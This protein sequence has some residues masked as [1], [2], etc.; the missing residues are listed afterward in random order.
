MHNKTLSVSSME[1]MGVYLVR[2]GF[3]QNF[4]LAPLF[5]LSC[6][7]AE[8]CHIFFSIIAWGK[9]GILTNNKLIGLKYSVH[10]CY[11]V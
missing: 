8:G 5:C 1:M 4:I 6:E 9:H 3:F 7:D 10:I 2:S 11:L